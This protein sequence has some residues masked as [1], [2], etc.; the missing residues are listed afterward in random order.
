VKPLR[1]KI[2]STPRRIALFAALAFAAAVFWYFGRWGFANMVASNADRTDIADMTVNW[3]P[4]DPQTHYA[5]AVLYDRTFLP[6]DQKRSLAEYERAVALSPENYLLWLE[7]GKALARS[8]DADRAEAALRQAQKLAPNYSLV[9]WTLGNTLVRDGKTDEG[10]DQ[11]RRS[12]AGDPT[13]A[14]PAVAIAYSYCSGD[15]ACIR[16]VVGQSTEANLALALAL[17]KDKRYGEAVDVWNSIQ[18]DA[19]DDRLTDA[20]HVLTVQLLGAKKFELARQVTSSFQPNAHAAGR[21]NDGGFEEGIKLEG[22]SDFDWQIT[23]GG[24]QPQILQS[25]SQPHSGSRCLVLLFNSNDGSGLRQLS[26]TVAVQPG[27]KYIL[28]GYYHTDIKSAGPLAW[29]VASGSNGAVIAE[30]PLK[31]PSQEWR[32]FSANFAVPQDTDGIVVRL[33]R[34]ACGAICPINGSMWLDDISISPQ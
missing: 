25:T 18:P 22:A 7:Y 27:G 32:E 33:S 15:L 28:A 20:R 6:D 12:I 21:I 4:N 10:F 1:F 34:T 31:D 5:A 9:Q 8:G 14:S 26:Q 11:V 17:A 30:I 13:Y 29:Q 23:A 16:A 19:V 3:A 2:D 24:S